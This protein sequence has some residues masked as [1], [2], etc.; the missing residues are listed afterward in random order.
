MDLDKFL[1]PELLA[2]VYEYIVD[3]YCKD[4]YGDMV[5]YNNGQ[6]INWYGVHEVKI[7]DRV[8]LTLEGDQ[9]N[10]N[11]ILFTGQVMFNGCVITL[12]DWTHHRNYVKQSK[13]CSRE[14]A[15]FQCLGSNGVK[16]YGR[17]DSLIYW[18]MFHTVIVYTTLILGEKDQFNHP[19]K[20]TGL[21][22]MHG[23]K[24]TIG[25]YVYEGS[26]ITW[27]I[28]NDLPPLTWDFTQLVQ[29]PKYL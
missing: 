23:C 12:N 1:L 5:H 7:R 18:P 19:I 4:F 22:E 25:A 8:I 24:I 21:V 10:N 28:I 9:F 14:E 26:N 3:I 27:D 15:D 11:R 20:I 2:I 16:W 6:Q 29:N 17:N 13:S